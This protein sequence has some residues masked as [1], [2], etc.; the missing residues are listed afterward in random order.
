[1][2]WKPTYV[3]EFGAACEAALKKG[4]WG[5]W[6]KVKRHRGR[7][8]QAKHR[9]GQGE[10]KCTIS[11]PV[12]LGAHMGIGQCREQEGCKVTLSAQK[13][14]VIL[15]WSSAHQPLWQTFFGRSRVCK[16]SW[17]NWAPLLAAAALCPLKTNH[18]PTINGNSNE[19]YLQIPPFYLQ[20][21]LK[22]LL[23]SNFRTSTSWL[24]KSP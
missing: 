13:I 18:R 23:L 14:Q 12:F 4:V 5:Q 2:N 7:I 24:K 22:Q 15:S 9:A 19:N 21:R 6:G 17:L 11:H 10:G 8:S 1:M 20:V 3:G 16:I